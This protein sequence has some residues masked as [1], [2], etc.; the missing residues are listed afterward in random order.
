MIDMRIDTTVID[1]TTAM[2]SAMR[3][4]GL[5]SGHSE[6]AR[7]LKNVEQGWTM[8]NALTVNWTTGKNNC[9]AIAKNLPAF[10]KKINDIC[11]DTSQGAEMV[12]PN[13]ALAIAAAESNGNPG[14]KNG[15]I[16]GMMQ[17]QY[18]K[19]EDG[20]L[21]ADGQ[22]AS[23]T[24]YQACQQQVLDGIGHMRNKAK[25]VGVNVSNMFPVSI[26]YNAGQAIMIGYNSWKGLK[27]LGGAS[28]QNL[29]NLIDSYVDVV[30]GG[31]AN[32][33]QEIEEYYPRVLGA[34]HYFYSTDFLSKNAND[35]A[36]LPSKFSLNKA[37]PN[38]N[39][40]Y[41]PSTAKSTGTGIAVDGGGG[42]EDNI[43]FYDS[44]KITTS[45]ETNSETDFLLDPTEDERK[46]GPNIYD[47]QQP[48]IRF[49]TAYGVEESASA[50]D[51]LFRYSRFLY[52]FLNS[53]IETATVQCIA[54]PWIRAGFN[55]WYDPGHE[56]VVYY[57][58]AVEHQGNPED[59]ATTTLNL[60]LGRTSHD[61]VSDGTKFGGLNGNQNNMFISSF[62][63]A[64]R[65]GKFGNTI[66]STSAFDG[67]RS[68]AEN[69][70]NA[71]LLETTNADQS[72]YHKQFYGTDDV[73]PKP[74]GINSDKIFSGGMTREQIDTQM[75]R[76]YSSAPPVV[77]NRDSQLKQMVELAKKYIDKFHILETHQSG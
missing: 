63:E 48:L 45:W 26:S 57:C 72:S 14:S 15:T 1:K 5:S 43:Y 70:Y 28:F 46:Y 71:E 42:D 53:R 2:A 40:G 31:S 34:W 68:A 74:S 38:A 33:K 35:P 66:A 10:L 65:A 23:G 6:Y 50:A 22:I 27:N 64:Y 55:V 52:Y 11:T 21:V 37:N 7:I 47:T 49:S 61:F 12:D 44:S 60:V 18:P 59:G 77:K 17:V 3:E 19:G 13:F 73:A 67:V 75:N 36:I 32:K 9:A 29:L 4:L 58:E 54:M 51:A 41:S 24:S 69:Y 30:F 39:G 20:K 76:L 56:D 25:A 8:A 62:N 16:I